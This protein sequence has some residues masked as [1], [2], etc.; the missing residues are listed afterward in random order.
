M[1]LII[2]NLKSTLY[3]D[4]TQYE[5]LTLSTIMDTFLAPVIDA[6]DNPEFNTFQATDCIT[7]VEIMQHFKEIASV[8]EY[9][10]WVFV[11]SL[12][13][14]S[15]GVCF[16]SNGKFCKPFTRL[17][18]INRV[19][20][21]QTCLTSTSPTKRCVILILQKIICI[22]TIGNLTGRLPNAILD[23]L[24]YPGQRLERPLKVIEPTYSFCQIPSQDS[25]MFV[26]VV[27]V[28]SGAGAG[29]VAS[30][31]AK[32]GK[33]VLVLEKGKYVETKEFS[34]RESHQFQLLFDKGGFMASK[35]T[36]VSI[37][38]GSTWGGG[39]T[40]NWC[41]SLVPPTLLRKEWAEK[42][43]LKYFMTEEFQKS[44]EF[45][46]TRL[47][48]TEDAI[49]H[50][51]PN[52]F[53]IDA[54]NKVGHPVQVI[55]QNTASK[56]HECGYCGFGCPSGVKRSSA[57]T[58]LQDAF[59]HGARFF[60]SC[61]VEKILIQNGKAKGVQAKIQ[62]RILTV[63]AKC[64]VV[65]GGSIHSPALLKRS[66]LRN[67]H[68]GK[69]LGLHP[70]RIV[71]AY[72]KE[73][74]HTFQGSIM[75]TVTDVPDTYGVK[76]EIPMLHPSSYAAILPFYDPAQYKKDL[77]KYP[78]VLP[79]IVLVK[80]KNP[81]ASIKLDLEGK[82][83]IEFLLSQEDQLQMEK[84]VLFAIDLLKKLDVVESLNVN[85]DILFSAHQMGSCRMAT[86]P[87]FGVCKPT[88][89][90]WEVRHLYVADASVFPTS[91]GVNPMLT[92]YSVAHS[93]ANFI[94]KD[95]CWNAFKS[96]L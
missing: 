48:V 34:Y 74:I 38:A 85:R 17:S 2:D 4:L 53:L 21:F 12:L 68:V 88:G 41:A 35:D 45:V 58:F 96:N 43:G 32:A 6:T 24:E 57:Q 44:V 15:M 76:L 92:V 55:P 50:N 36:T 80:D 83:E 7:P 28:G 42:Y 91:S 31:L 23:A 14:H 37:L 54:C 33:V 63:Y 13:S 67:K 69:H 25:C 49:K 29:I 84:G 39:T 82:P 95:E 56:P 47:G 70:V 90:T 81:L 78:Y 26:D 71:Y 93:I 75:T 89:E 72:C 79:V 10:K 3:R 16:F 5:L 22:W 30:E 40:V 18:L 51:K 27:I 61:Y 11:L 64:V 46:C 86:T 87:A 77:L 73:P 94:L 62:G 1:D 20:L 52:Q 19:D 66:G 59:D 65:S 60:H 8:R 9:S